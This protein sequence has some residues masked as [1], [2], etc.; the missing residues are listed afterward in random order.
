[1]LVELNDQRGQPLWVHP[2]GVMVVSSGPPGKENA[3][4]GVLLDSREDALL[5][6]GLSAEQV[7]GRLSCQQQPIRVSL[8]DFT[9]EDGTRE[10]INTKGVRQVLARGAG[11]EIILS[12]LQL[13]WG[14]F[15]RLALEPLAVRVRESPDVVRAVINQAM[16]TESGPL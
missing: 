6:R 12:R 16:E 9:D 4:C 14:L 11:T 5:V 7:V 8:A 13:T 10:W 1:M 15:R 2:G 3:Q